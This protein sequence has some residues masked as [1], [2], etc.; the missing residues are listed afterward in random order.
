MR[1]ICPIA[2]GGSIDAVARLVAGR[3]AEIW[4]QQTVVENRT[5][6]VSIGAEAVARSEPDGYTIFVTPSSLAMASLLFSSLNYD[7]VADFAP[8]S[9]I[10]H[11]PNIMVVPISSPAHSVKEFIAYAK[12][13]PGKITYASGGFGSSLH[14][15]GELFKRITGIEMTH[16]PYR[17]AAPAFNDLIPGRVDVMFNLTPSS[18]PLIRGGKI[19]GL[20]VATQERVAVIPELPTLT[21]AGV[22]GMELSSW[23]SL[24]VPARTP[25]EIVRKIHAGT[26]TA[27]A[28]P[29]TRRKLEDMG[30]VVVGS[31][32]A[33]LA[34]QVKAD[35]EKWGPIIKEAG[36]SIRE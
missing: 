32:P 35:I 11:Y 18:L 13:R 27:L 23:I 33:E 9:L 5:G 3:L 24:F 2:A 19:R 8:V 17:G 14:L 4:H 15:A 6:N 1:F 25:P 16:I 22:P 12:S 36:I 26:V 21:E 7:P 29:A 10:G 30:V 31:T 34:A 28:E 20:A